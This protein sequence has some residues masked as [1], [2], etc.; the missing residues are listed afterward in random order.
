MVILWL[1]CVLPGR[2]DVEWDDKSA[3]TLDLCPCQEEFNSTTITP[4]PGV[5]VMCFAL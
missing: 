1:I 2:V 4:T 5:G 3:K